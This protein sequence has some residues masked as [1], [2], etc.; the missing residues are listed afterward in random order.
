[1]YYSEIRICLMAALYASNAMRQMDLKWLSYLATSVRNRIYSAD[2]FIATHL[3]K[4]A[5]LRPTEEDD[6]LRLG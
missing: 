5:S 3:G 1:M 2:T 6:W 4:R